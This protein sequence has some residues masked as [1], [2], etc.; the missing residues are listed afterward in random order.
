MVLSIA[1]KQA[2]IAAKFEV[3]PLADPSKA[4]KYLKKTRLKT[5]KT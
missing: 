4:K 3:V 1:S 5:K 2:G